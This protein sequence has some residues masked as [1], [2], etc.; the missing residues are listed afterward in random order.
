VI[1]P[2]QHRVTPREDDDALDTLRHL[3]EKACRPLKRWRGI[4]TRYANHTA[5]L[6][7]AVHIRCLALWASVS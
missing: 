6:L 3:R 4:A 5:S 2:N 7:A 1:P